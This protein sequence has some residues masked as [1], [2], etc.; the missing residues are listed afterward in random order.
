MKNQK[1]KKIRINLSEENLKF[2]NEN[3]IK[4]S[5]FI[6]NI[7]NEIRGGSIEA[8]K[9]IQNFDKEFQK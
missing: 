5:R 2:L 6:N 7:I 1:F 9:R 3:N 8:I 4:I